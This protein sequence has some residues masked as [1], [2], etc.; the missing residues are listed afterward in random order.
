MADG[1]VVGFV[2]LKFDKDGVRLQFS[3][4]ALPVVDS[5]EPTLSLVYDPDTR[6]VKVLAGVQAKDDGPS[7]PSP[8]ASKDDDDDNSFDVDLFNLPE[9]YQRLVNNRGANRRVTLPL[10]TP[11]CAALQRGGDFMSYQEYRQMSV[12]P[13]VRS[14][15]A[16]GA[17]TNLL[18]LNLTRNA[19]NAVIYPP[20]TKE[21]FDYMVRRCRGQ[22]F[23][24]R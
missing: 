18:D 22:K 24:G 6:K 1:E 15:A 16:A 5:V 7:P 14:F 12:R 9:E 4:P 17:P 11:A 21:M 13:K 8:G 23:F 2:T 19:V 3:G 10:P 20:L